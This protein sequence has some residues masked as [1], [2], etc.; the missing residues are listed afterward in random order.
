MIT[1]YLQFCINNLLDIREI[2][3]NDLTLSIYKKK[4]IKK[5]YYNMIAGA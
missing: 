1:F 5:L 3:K 2:F 4:T